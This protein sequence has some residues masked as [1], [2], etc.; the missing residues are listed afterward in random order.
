MALLVFSLSLFFAVLIS[1]RAERGVLSTSV[2]FLLAGIFAGN[3]GIGVIPL[4]PTNPVV[5]RFVELALFTVLFTDGMRVDVGRLK[6]AWRLPGRAL[7][8]GLPLTLLF[9]GIIAHLLLGFAWLPAM[10]MGAALSPTDPVFASAIV[11][12]EEVP[13]RLRGLLNV[14]SGFNDGLALPVVLLLMRALSRQSSGIWE[15]VLQIAAGVG[16]GIAL[17]WAAMRAEKLPI[18][19]VAS[20]YQP[21]TGFAIGLMILAVTSTAHANEF[22]G[23]F[24]GGIMLAHVSPPT[25]ESFHH[26]GEL[27]AELFK[28]AS[29]MIFGALISFEFLGDIGLSGWIFVVLVLLAVRPLAMAIL[30]VGGQLSW[31]EWVTAAWFGPRGFATVFFSLLILQSGVPDRAR[32]YHLLFV[33]VAAS[34]VAHSS[35]D[36]LVARWFRKEEGESPPPQREAEPAGDRNP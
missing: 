1:C 5:Q 2:L 27:I 25:A 18:F 33:V 29:L 34:I 23:A 3:G 28:L 22:L 8:F 32:I 4:S 10:L 12:R 13:R 15:I 14:E 26:F 30:L 9:S 16:I 6:S 36:V 35:T 21:L 19:G 31:P 20:A 7:F 17:P 11:G 24:A